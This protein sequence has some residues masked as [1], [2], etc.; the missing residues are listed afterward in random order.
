MGVGGGEGRRGGSMSLRGRGGMLVVGVDVGGKG[1]C[2]G[3]GVRGR[4]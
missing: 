4:R 3:S 2:G 1:G